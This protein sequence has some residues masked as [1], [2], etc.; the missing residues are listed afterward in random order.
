MYGLPDGV[1]AMAFER[2]GGWTVVAWNEGQTEAAFRLA[3]PGA[4]KTV[5]TAVATS[6]TDQLSPTARPAHAGADGWS[7]H[8]APQTVITYTFG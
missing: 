6:A 2:G 1:R 5:R 7:V 4:R 3:L 8:I